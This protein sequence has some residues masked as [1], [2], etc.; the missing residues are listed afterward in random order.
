[1]RIIAITQARSGS[2]RLPGKIFKIA[3][4]KTLLQ[5]HLERVKRS[6]RIHQLIVATTH[7][8]EDDKICKL[9]SAMNVEYSRG[10]IDDVLDRF[11]QAAKNYNPDYVVRVTSD[12]PLIDPG[13]IDLVIDMAVNTKSDYGS[14]ILKE[15]FPDGQDIEVFRFSALERAWKEAT[16]Q[17]EREH[18]TPYIRKHSDFNGDTLFKAVNFESEENYGGVRMTVDEMAD[19]EVIRD[20]IELLG[21][22][23]AWKTYADHILS[24]KRIAEKNAHITRNEGY[25]KSINKDHSHE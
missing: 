20:L 9:A 11:Y 14:N 22:E 17:S 16:L 18:V 1:M 24:N 7:L 13:L 12:C 2:T 15:T 23:E 19:Y 25:H 6:K 21:T 10:S 8:E 3:N 4:G 5:V